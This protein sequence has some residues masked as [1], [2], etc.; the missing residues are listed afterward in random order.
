M[1]CPTA[2]PYTSVLLRISFL[3]LNSSVYPLVFRRVTSQ[4]QIRLGHHRFLIVGLILRR[5]TRALGPESNRV[6]V[7]PLRAIL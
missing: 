6:L 5:D 4:R 7:R 3:T 2:L 1:G